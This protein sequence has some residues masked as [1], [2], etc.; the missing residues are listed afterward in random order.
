MTLQIGDAKLCSTFSQKQ[1]LEQHT[2][3]VMA[4]KQQ[5]N[6]NK[7]QKLLTFHL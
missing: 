7:V 6:I 2:Q 1:L 4:D 3:N 5:E